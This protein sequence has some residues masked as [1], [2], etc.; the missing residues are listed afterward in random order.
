MKPILCRTIYAEDEEE[1]KWVAGLFNVI[2]V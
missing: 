2:E 1:N